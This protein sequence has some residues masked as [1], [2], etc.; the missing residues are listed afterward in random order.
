MI[1]KVKVCSVRVKLSSAI[2]QII[3]HLIS[4]SYIC[5][6]SMQLSLCKLV[7]FVRLLFLIWLPGFI[8]SNICPALFISL[9]FQH[10]N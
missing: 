2:C 10:V 9:V 7:N 1:C 4:Q 5:R 8:V 6:D 3:I